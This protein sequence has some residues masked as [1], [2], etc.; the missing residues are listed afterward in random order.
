MRRGSPDN[1]VQHWAE[2]LQLDTAKALAYY[3][4]HFYGRWPAITSNQYGA[5]KVIYQGTYL[6]DTLQK[7]VLQSALQELGLTGP[8]QQL[9]PSVRTR[10]GIN[11]FKRPV[12]Y[13]FNYSGAEVS[14]SYARKNGADLL[15]GRRVANA[16][17]L[18][19][20]P[21]DLAII[22]EDGK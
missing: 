8:A 18:T 20:R 15:S 14:F 19:L 16:D 22:E 11:S 1:K 17:K 9:P 5:G 7:A 6:S 3:D 4:H 2:F 12:H 10:T 21:W 13:Y